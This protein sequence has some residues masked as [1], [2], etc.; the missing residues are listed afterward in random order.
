MKFKKLNDA[1]IKIILTKKDIKSNN[2]SIENILSNSEESQ[3]LLESMIVLAKQ[4][5]GFEPG[6]AK[7]LV[8]AIKNSDEEYVFTI[9]KLCCE[10][11]CTNRHFSSFIFKFNCFDDLMHLCIFL[12]NLSNLNLKAFSKNFS[13]IFYNGTYFLQALDVKAFSLA[14]EYARSVFAEF[15]KDVSNL[16]GIDGILNEYGKIVFPK[17]AILKSII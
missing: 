9:T 11:V 16:A 1:K 2:I 4:K 3:E 10:Q 14:L 5:I 8:E 6:N 17:D 13:L 12:K 15:G 7:L